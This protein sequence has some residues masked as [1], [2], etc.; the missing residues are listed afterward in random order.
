MRETLEYVSQGFDL[1]QAQA[2]KTM[3][4]IMNGEWTPSQIAG[5]TMALKIKGETVDE[6]SGFVTAMRDKASSIA[7]PA[8]AIDVVG[9]GG[10]GLHTVNISTAAALVTAAAGVPVAKH[11][12]RSVSSRT[13][14]AD[15][16]S[17]LGVKIDL[18]PEQAEKCLEEIGF[19]FLFAPIYHASMKYAVVPRKEMGIRTVF[20]I[21]GPMCNPALVKN[22]L[23]GAFTGEAAEKMVH[24]LK[25]TGSE[26]SL[27]V[28]SADGMDE[29]SLSSETQVYELKDSHIQSYEIAPEKFGYERVDIAAITGGE[30][31][32]NA[33]ILKK[34]FAGADGPVAKITCMNAGAALYVAGKTDSLQEGAALAQDVLSSGIV[35]EQLQRLIDFTHSVN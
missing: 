23:V 19:V 22:Q 15:V 12:N 20:N 27:V 18:T 17:S 5:F 16:L 2:H 26:H 6:I 9:T 29:I 13:G 8:G 21:L 14:S 33:E 24:V 11:G 35:K 30:S 7:A 28:H 25:R 31:S 4:D 34:L 32:E 10:D 3:L 1:T